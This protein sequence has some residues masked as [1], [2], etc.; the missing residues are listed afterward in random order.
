MIHQDKCAFVG[1]SQEE[2]TQLLTT[3]DLFF[4]TTDDT[5]DEFKSSPASRTIEKMTY[6]S[7]DMTRE[8]THPC[9][10]TVKI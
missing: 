8:D 2:S 9:A 3:D 1:L 4:S 5:G 10:Y 7:S 6:L